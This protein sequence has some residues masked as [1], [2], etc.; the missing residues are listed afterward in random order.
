MIVVYGLKTCDTCRKALKWL[1][2]E[3]I[4]H[5]FHDLRADGLPEA[6]LRRWMAAVGPDVLVN[7]RG[8]TWRGLPAEEQAA[9]LTAERAVALALTHPALLKRPVFDLGGTVTV[10]FKPAQQEAL[11]EAAA[12]SSTPTAA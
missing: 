9:D 3:G 7:R 12:G 4:A 10:G 6:D 2:E 5:R 8:T 11:R 1:M